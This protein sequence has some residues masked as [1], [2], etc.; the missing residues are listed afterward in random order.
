MA[1]S[2]VTATRILERLATTWPKGVAIASL[3]N[4]LAIR[5]S[6]CFS[7]MSTLSDEGWAVRINRQAGW[8]LGPKVFEIVGLHSNEPFEEI[9]RDLAELAEDLGLTVFIAQQARSGEYVVIARADLARGVRI[10]VEVGDRFPMVAPA[11]MACFEVDSDPEEVASR[12]RAH[13]DP[14]VADPTLRTAAGVEQ[15]LAEIRTRGFASSVQRYDYAQ[16]G[17]AAPIYGARNTVVYSLCALGLSTVLNDE[18]ATSVGRRIKMTA[19]LISGRLGRTGADTARLPRTRLDAA[20]GLHRLASPA[21]RRADD[22]L[23][24]TASVETRQAGAARRRPHA[25]GSKGDDV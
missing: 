6:T 15:L 19:D 11:L 25:S 13:P 5:R 4:E 20:R 1:N 21:D 16:S 22:P 9:Q 23:L 8:T 10:T 2:V 24:P 3:I 17:I 7:I 14:I 12:L 18:N